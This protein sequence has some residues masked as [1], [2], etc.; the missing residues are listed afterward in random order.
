M[1]WSPRWMSRTGS[2]RRR[3]DSRRLRVDSPVLGA[4]GYRSVVVGDVSDQ[5]DREEVRRVLYESVAHG[6][7]SVAGAREGEPVFSLTE[8]GNAHVEALIDAAITLYGDA[9]ADALAARLD[10]PVEMTRELVALRVAAGA[11]GEK[12]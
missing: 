8:A 11:D 5:P 12:P 3:D 6:H 7:L 10:L 1:C 4:R 2:R 9:A